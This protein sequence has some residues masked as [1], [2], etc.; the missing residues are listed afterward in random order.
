MGGRVE[1]AAGS[2]T[3]VRR[4]GAGGRPLVL[5]GGLSTWLEA[6][7]DDVSGPLW[8]GRL[9]VEAPDAVRT[10]H[11]AFAEAGA[12]VATTATYQLSP[13]GTARVLGT[14]AAGYRRLVATA[15]RLA[16]EGAPGALVAGSM[17][18]WGAVLAD[19]SEYTGAYAG[20]GGLGV[21]EL[22]RRHRPRLEALVE[23][24][25]DVLACETLPCL[26]EVEAIV[27]EVTE[28][29][30]T[31]WISVTAVLADGVPVTRRGEP[32]VE[33][34][35][36]AADLPGLLAAGVNCCAPE[37]VGPA[38]RAAAEAGVPLVAY[39]NGGRWDPARTTWADAGTPRGWAEQLA[40]VNPA[41]VGG[42]CGVGPEAIAQLARTVTQR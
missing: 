10:A 7:G 4:A 13:E 5:D 11:R 12:D 41:L 28:A 31:A 36:M 15:V 27:A 8:S 23:A 39:P 1:D 19:G 2:G 6:R 37:V 25:V 30:V 34:L 35:R 40:A 26:A 17:G 14:D 9:V 38:A 16:R 18:P 33:A 20:P 24:G 21:A 42:C 22:R 32:L 3:R 29:G